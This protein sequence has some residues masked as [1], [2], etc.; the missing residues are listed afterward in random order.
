MDIETR[1]VRKL[2][3]NWSLIPSHYEKTKG[4]FLN[5]NLVIT[6]DSGKYVLRKVTHFKNLE[7]IKQEIEHLRYLKDRNFEYETPDPVMTA[8]KN[9]FIK[10]Q[11]RYFWLYKYIDGEIKQKTTDGDLKQIAVMMTKYHSLIKGS[12]FESDI[13]MKDPF[14]K[15]AILNES[16]RLKSVILA[17]K[18]KMRKTRSFSMN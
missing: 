11:D 2:L 16:N 8:K 7:G 10:Y 14:F 18:K 1:R 15:N 17:K 13:E 5:D 9:Y 12:K 6:A 4:G 3:S